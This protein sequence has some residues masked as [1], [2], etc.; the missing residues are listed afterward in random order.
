MG[1]PILDNARC[2]AQ[3]ARHGAQRAARRSARPS[4]LRGEAHLPVEGRAAAMAEVRKR[5]AAMAA[6]HKR[7]GDGQAGR[8]AARAWELALARGR[9]DLGVSSRGLAKKL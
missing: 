8:G 6:A 3:R 9:R 5:C 4:S 7:C 2:R 1:R